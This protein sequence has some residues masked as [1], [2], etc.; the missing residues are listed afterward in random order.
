MYLDSNCPI[1][2]VKIDCS[3]NATLLSKSMPLPLPLF[4]TY[5]LL[6]S[7]PSGSKARVWYSSSC[8][9]LLL[10]FSYP[11][12]NQ[13]SINAQYTFHTTTYQFRNLSK[14]LWKIRIVKRK[15]LKVVPYYSFFIEI[16]FVP[17]PFSFK[18][19]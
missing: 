1:S 2:V 11:T 18:V 12:S 14:D 7:S 19:K 8:Q 5:L 17:L 13:C 3:H 4:I 15:L 6:L 9:R 16:S 10:A